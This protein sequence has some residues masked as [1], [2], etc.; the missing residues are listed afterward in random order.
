MNLELPND[1]TLVTT[2]MKSYGSDVDGAILLLLNFATIKNS[3][4][5]LERFRIY[6]LLTDVV[7]ALFRCAKDYD[8]SEN[9]H[10]FNGPLSM[11]LR[12][13]PS[14]PLFLSSSSK[15]TRMTKIEKRSK[16]EGGVL[17]ETIHS[18]SGGQ[19]TIKLLFFQILSTFLPSL[20]II[21]GCG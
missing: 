19:S 20:L 18:F 4:C 11:F 12:R 15:S 8:E 17:S 5:D 21:I 14:S 7:P 3:S 1:A 16:Q 13:N 2:T 10:H 6:G 9:F